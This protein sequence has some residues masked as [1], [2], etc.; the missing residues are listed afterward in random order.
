MR[1]RGSGVKR[2]VHPEAGELVLT[3][4]ALELP[5]DPGQRLCTYTAPHD[6]ET[7][8]KLRDL[9]TRMTISV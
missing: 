8:R 4:E 1:D 5:T 2:V 6:S 3:F 9:A 7:E